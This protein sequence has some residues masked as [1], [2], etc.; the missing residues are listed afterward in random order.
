MKLNNG[1]LASIL[2]VDDEPNN[3]D[4]VEAALMSKNY[5]L[6]YASNAHQTWQQLKSIPIDV[7]LL[8][9]MMPD[10]DGISLCQ[11]LKAHPQWQTISILMITALT[12][13][14]DLA[15]SLD[16]GADDFLSKPFHHL[17]LQARV[18]SLIR[19]KKQQDQLRELLESRGEELR[20][21]QQVE[22]ALAR[23]NEQLQAVIDAVPGFISWISKDL[24]Y[25]GV[26]QRLAKAV[27]MTPEAF[28][29]QRLGFLNSAQEFETFVAE[30]INQSQT[31][32]LQKVLQINS[33]GTTREY[34]IVAQKYEQ[35]ESIVTVGIDITEWKQ[36]E[37]ELK[38]TSTQ[39][40]TLLNTLKSGVLLQDKAG[41]V[42]LPNQQF[43]QLFEIN[44]KSDN[45][46]GKSNL[47]LEKYYYDSV[48]NPEQFCQS[49]QR[50][51][52]E[53]QFVNNE[54]W[55]LQNGRILE[56]D[57]APIVLDGACQGH[58]WMYRDITERKQNEQEL[59]KSLQEKELLLK[60]IHHRVKN[61]L[62][63]VSNLLDLQSDYVADEK[64][65]F[66]LNESRNRVHT[67]ALVH[68]KL[69]RNTGLSKINFAEYLEDLTDTLLDSYLSDTQKI[70]L[71][72]RLEP[73]WLN[74]ETANPC[75]LIVNELI[76]NALKHGFPDLT[77]GK[78]GIELSQHKAD[79]QIHLKVS[80]NGIGLPQDFDPMAVKS[81]GMEL[82]LT[83]TEQIQGQFTIDHQKQG[84]S[85]EITFQEVNYRQRY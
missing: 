31:N 7:I 47:D 76:S 79:Q 12:A 77:E 27:E 2:V 8:D 46:I 5:Q 16:V 59:K 9:V 52:Q 36:S 70:Q 40:T 55:T 28:I 48:S 6:H 11:E 15:R 64:L 37:R 35:G 78:I 80:D 65:S 45:L 51:L 25:R 10:Q 82:I 66:L 54:E 26:N 21:R 63:V 84:V 4:V 50:L 72:L 61:N 18:N 67:M 1:Q 58:L 56:R 69:Y 23:S 32:T 75:G 13:K 68:Q 49:N 38:V 34:L 71:E 39:M 29:G 62:L 73:I 17:E 19:I 22:V 83:L 57:Y 81:L 53:K 60:E 44:L 33:Q 30:F 42:I 43:Y 20:Y 41:N 85:F 3:F 24:H 14:E 74:I